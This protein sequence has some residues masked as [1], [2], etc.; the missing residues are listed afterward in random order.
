MAL[1]LDAA[2][3]A[4]APA[5]PSFEDKARAELEKRF[6]RL[7]GAS[8]TNL[9]THCG[10]CIDACHV[11]LATGDVRLSP[12]AKA[13]QVR[14]HYKRSH[15]WMS[16]IF[17]RWTGAKKE[18]TEEDVD[19]WI[20]AAFQA[21]T[22]CERCVINCPMGVETPQILAAARGTLT[23]LGKAPE[24]LDQLADA[25]IAREE[26]M[27][28]FKEFFL[29]QIKVLEEEVRDKL[30]D[31]AA[32]IPVNEPS[33]ILYVP[34]SGAHTIVPQAIIFNALGVS[35]SLSMFEASN[36]AMFIGDVP[37]AK[38]IAMRVISEAERL[39]TKQLIISECGHAYAAFKW[40]APKW[41]GG[42]LPFEVK[43]VVELLFEYV[44][45]R[46]LD[47]D[48]GRN[49]EP[50][51]YHDPCNLGRKGGVFEEPRAVI[52]ASSTDYR[53]MTPSRSQ[54]FC[55]GGGGGLVAETDWEEERVIFGKPK[56]EQIRATG[57]TKVIT[58]C[59]NCRHQIAELGEHYGID[60]TVQSV[61]E[62]L[63]DALVTKSAPIGAD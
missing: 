48:P 9:C 26:H 17:P 34:L 3:A 28:M 21:C 63:V 29:E 18:L 5:E 10:W 60:L 59:D 20:E 39:G 57:A 53:E 40:E 16:R 31:P 25:A 8:A 52:Q 50:I 43:S 14:T 24:I 49:S 4:E 54:N 2:T 41:F 15:D 38:K 62:L 51:T 37:R 36:Y 19:G 44:D 7:V 6:S 1:D 33:D 23:A 27:D 47:L 12:V 61:T 56:A 13:E 55:C 32:R 35:W 42:P 30:G 58:S 22:L 45:A 11:F 46:L